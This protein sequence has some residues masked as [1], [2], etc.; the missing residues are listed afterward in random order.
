MTRPG[1]GICCHRETSNYGE[2][3]IGG[4]AGDHQLGTASPQLT[5]SNLNALLVFAKTNDPSLIPG[6]F[7]NV[8]VTSAV[9]NWVFVTNWSI[10]SY[11]YTPNGAPYGTQILVVYS[12]IVGTAWQPV[13]QDTF[14]NVITN[15]NLANY[16]GIVL[17]GG[18]VVL[19]YSPNTPATLQTFQVSQPPGAPYGTITTN[20]TVQNIVISNMPSGEYL[21]IPA[22]QCGWKI[23]NYPP[24]WSVV[25]ITERHRAGHQHLL[26]GHRHQQHVCRFAEHRIL[27]HQPHVSGAADQLFP[28]H[29][30][31][32]LV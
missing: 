15:G 5:T 23:L 13:Y 25:A 4:R 2:C 27:L 28:V 18:N 29:S 10:G 11:L 24:S 6:T 7:P 12:N 20:T 9:T 17:T 21:S 1:C 26:D 22:S 30:R 31:R 3:R 16:P 19:N 32:R 8:V 14:A